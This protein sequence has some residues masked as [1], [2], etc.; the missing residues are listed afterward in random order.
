MESLPV[1]EFGRLALQ[2]RCISLEHP[3]TCR[4]L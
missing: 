3:R 4:P 1:T 2:A